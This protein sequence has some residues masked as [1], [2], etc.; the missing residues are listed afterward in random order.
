MIHLFTTPSMKR[1]EGISLIVSM[2]FLTIVS[3]LAIV[4]IRGV[5]TQERMAGNT[6]DW[7]LAFQAAEAA[8]RDAEEDIRASGRIRDI[9]GFI[10]GCDKGTLPQ[11]DRMQGL[12]LPAEEGVPTWQEPTVWRDNSGIGLN[13][14]NVNNK[15]TS[16]AYGT[17][18]KAARLPEVNTPPRYII[19]ALGPAGA[20]SSRSRGYGD[21]SPT[22]HA[23][24]ITAIGF[25]N[26]LDSDGNPATRVFAQN[27]FT[28]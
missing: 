1:Q 27:V 5:T 6:Q 22:Y 10:Y 2:I 19:E 4:A 12:C 25:G 20:N 7:N 26:I 23:Y 24:R 8:L 28:N 16:V 9:E 14:G 17:F 18:T 3:L 13:N 11:D 15:L 21:G